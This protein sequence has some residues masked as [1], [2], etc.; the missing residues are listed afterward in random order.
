MGSATLG[1]VALAQ[2]H[3]VCGER[4]YVV[5]YRR[6]RRIAA[7]VSYTPAT[8]APSWQKWS[9]T[10]VNDDPYAFCCIH[11]GGDAD[12]A[13]VDHIRAWLADQPAPVPIAVG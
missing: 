11:C 2:H 4:L 10:H 1:E 13:H 6:S 7:V 12:C 8:D 5:R 9:P 3:L